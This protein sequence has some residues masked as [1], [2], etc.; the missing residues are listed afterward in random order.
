MTNLKRIKEMDE[1]ELA[2]FLCDLCVDHSCERVC[3]YADRC[4]EMHAQEFCAEQIATWLN[5]ESSE[6]NY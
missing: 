3:A 4:I 2:E 1:E 6:R 5:K